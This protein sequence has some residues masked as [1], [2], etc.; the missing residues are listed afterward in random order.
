MQKTVEDAYKC[1]ATFMDLFR[2]NVN[3]KALLLTISLIVFQQFAGINVV[4]F[5]S[6]KI[7]DAAGTSSSLSSAVSTIIIGICSFLPSLITPFIVDRWG[8]KILLNTSAIGCCISLV[9]S[10]FKF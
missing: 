8:R 7:F 3:F 6:Q 4:I 5:Y 2:V 9:T 10:I 1:E